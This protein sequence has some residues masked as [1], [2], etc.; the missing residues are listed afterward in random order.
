MCILNEWLQKYN[1][2][3]I[4]QD[5]AQSIE[6]ISLFPVIGEDMNATLFIGWTR[7]FFDN[8]GTDEVILVHRRDV[9]SLRGLSLEEVF[10]ELSNAMALYNRWEIKLLLEA[11]EN[12]PEQRIIDACADVLGPMV[13]IDM[14]FNIMAISKKYT[15]G[16]LNDIWDEFIE[17]GTASLKNFESMRKSW[18]FRHMSEHYHCFAYVEPSIPNYNNA[19]I[20]SYTDRENNLIGQ[21]LIISDR[22]PTTAE[23]QLAH[24]VDLALGYIKNKK[25]RINNDE[26]VQNFLTK[27]LVS[28]APDKRSE[29]LLLFFNGWRKEDRFRIIRFEDRGN[30][31]ASVTYLARNVRNSIM[32][33]AVTKLDNSL[34]CCVNETQGYG[35]EDR[36]KEITGNLDIACGVSAAYV[37]LQNIYL[38]EKQARDAFHYG[39]ITSRKICYFADF[40]FTILLNN[41][42]DRVYRRACVHPALDMLREYDAHHHTQLFQTLHV[43]L[44]CERSYL[45]ASQLMHNHRNTVIVRVQKIQELFQLNLDSP[46]EREYLLLSYRLMDL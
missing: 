9:I 19:I 42:N 41:L 36:I 45:I 11:Q 28:P 30:H 35:L 25:D 20:M 10:Q 7:D 38:Q 21:M 17:Y 26:Y 44:Q 12:N 34:I 8:Q 6:K 13:L 23:S 31:A 15:K 46:D 32:K 39:S 14:E 5:S 24:T 37:G 2:V 16:S 43:F 4:I 29:D 33:S 3:S 1:P 40:A 22:L 27:L 18:L